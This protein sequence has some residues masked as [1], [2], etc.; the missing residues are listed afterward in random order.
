MFARIHIL[1]PAAQNLALAIPREAIIAVGD[2]AYVFV[3]TTEREFER[4]NIVPGPM[5]G[6]LVEIHEGLKAG[7]RVVVKGALLLKG[8]LDK[9]LS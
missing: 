5:S 8:A 4:R 9:R 3:Q 1:K 6:D 7:E 2:E